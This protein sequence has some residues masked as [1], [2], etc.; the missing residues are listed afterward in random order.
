MGNCTSN[1]PNEGLPNEGLPN[2]GLPNKESSDGQSSDDESY[3]QSS[4]ERLPNEESSDDESSDDEYS[5]DELR[6]DITFAY[7]SQCSV[8]MF[9]KKKTP[10]SAPKYCFCYKHYLEAILEFR[11]DDYFFTFIQKA[12]EMKHAYLRAKL[13]S[14]H[15]PFSE[16]PKE[17]EPF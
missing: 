7:Y 8:E 12:L 2:E 6:Q 14:E 11:D 10:D 13:L 5:D 17:E 15:F 3:E 9:C 1:K 16:I 4:D